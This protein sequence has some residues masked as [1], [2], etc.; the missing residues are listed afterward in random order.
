MSFMISQ[1]LVDGLWMLYANRVN[2][3][4][5]DAIILSGLKKNTMMKCNQIQ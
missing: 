2:V 5:M 1:K 4:I 3:L